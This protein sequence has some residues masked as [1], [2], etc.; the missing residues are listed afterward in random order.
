MFKNRINAVRS[1]LAAGALVAGSAAHAALPTAV[2][3]AITE[4]QTDALAAIGL[5][6]AA[7]VAIWGLMKLASKLGWR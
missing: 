2:G 7:G 6:M 4:Y 5:V 3:E 1:L